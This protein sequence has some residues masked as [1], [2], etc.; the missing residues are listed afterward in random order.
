VTN[1]RSHRQLI[2][3]IGPALRTLK[4]LDL[5]ATI[6]R[7]GDAVDDGMGAVATDAAHVTGSGG[8]SSTTERLALGRAD[9]A[10]ADLADLKRLL[11]MTLDNLHA[12]TAI[13]RRWP[14]AM[15]RREA[16]TA[17]P[18]NDCGVC[19]RYTTGAASDRLR[20]LQA[21]TTDGG[22]GGGGVRPA[23]SARATRAASAGAGSSPT[24]PPTPTTPQRGASTF[25]PAPTAQK[26]V[27]R[28]EPGVA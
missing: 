19:G 10:L 5:P 9:Q 8:G 22:G 7:I 24:R 1:H 28:L 11:A 20:T 17:S 6:V 14:V 13:A 12:I 4:A 27:S 18:G 2:H 26:Y 15:P 16:P 3:A 23:R 25:L 21:P